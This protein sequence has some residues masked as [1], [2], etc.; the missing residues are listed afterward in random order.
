MR[1][2][3]YLRAY[4]AGIVLPTAFLLVIMT[5]DVYH[6]YYLEVSSQFVLGMP[7]RPLERTLVFP[8]AI[9]PN[10]WGLWNMLHLALRPRI[11]L[12]LGAHGAL[13]VVL[14]MPAGALLAQ[15]FDAF[16]INWGLALPMLPLG[17]AVYYLV[18]KYAVGFLNEEVGVGAI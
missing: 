1:T 10:A 18:W 14:L 9:V 13:L 7:A 3:P 17:V 15:A 6:R 11:Q 2:H 16:T 12:P 5:V 4:M 8:M